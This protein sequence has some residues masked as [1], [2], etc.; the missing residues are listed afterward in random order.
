M[1][2][3]LHKELFKDKPDGAFLKSRELLVE[4]ISVITAERCYLITLESVHNAGV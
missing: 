4:T 3:F 2:N 1:N